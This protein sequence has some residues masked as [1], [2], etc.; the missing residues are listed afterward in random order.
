M[1][2]RGWDGGVRKEFSK[3]MQWP[4][5]RRQQLLVESVSPILLKGRCDA[6]SGDQKRGETKCQK[7]SPEGPPGPDWEVPLVPL[8]R[9]VGVGARRSWRRFL[10]YSGLQLQQCGEDPEKPVS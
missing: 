3:K 1:R 6:G 9:L 4:E 8:G 2:G 7:A 5:S 10:L